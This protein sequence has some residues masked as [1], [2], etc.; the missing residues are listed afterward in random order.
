MLC[1]ILY[2]LGWKSPRI[3]REF[4]RHRPQ[5]E[6]YRTDLLCWRAR[7]CGGYLVVKREE[8]TQEGGENRVLMSFVVCIL[9]QVL[10]LRLE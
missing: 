4:K 9:H 3:L 1:D 7:F 2:Y 5:S 10:L 6:S 8:V